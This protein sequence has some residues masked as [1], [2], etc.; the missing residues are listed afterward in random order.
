MKIFRG[1]MFQQKL[2][3]NIYHFQVHLQSKQ[4]QKR[5]YNKIFLSIFWVKHKAT[6]YFHFQ[7]FLFYIKFYK[8]KN[9]YLNDLIRNLFRS[10]LPN[11]S[12]FDLTR[13]FW[14]PSKTTGED[15]SSI[16]RSLW[17]R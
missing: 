7:Y 1:F 4:K 10:I 2:Y 6:E 15:L 8:L 5:L 13:F 16:Y 11:Q 14:K 12:R 9:M 17:R 3:Y